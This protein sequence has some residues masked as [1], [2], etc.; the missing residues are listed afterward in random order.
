MTGAG[1]IDKESNENNAMNHIILLGDSVFDN[2]EYVGENSSV[3]DALKS[4]MDRNAKVTLLAVDGNVTADV[5]VQLQSLPKNATHLFISCGGNDALRQAHILNE[6]V[7]SV[8]D[9]MMVLFEVIKE[10][11]CNY[12][13][14]LKTA[15][16]NNKNIALCTIYNSS[17][18]I[19]QQA[20]T[21][22]A[23]FNEIILH[24]AVKHQLPVIDL[25]MLCSEA[26]DFSKISPIEPSAIGASKIAGRIKSLVNYHQYGS[27]ET[28]IYT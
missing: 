22:L 20:F 17:P 4:I 27:S 7:T 21:V 9:A 12:H 18:G 24:E 19:S 13:R 6:R 28:R 5:L 1:E 11:Q 26:A 23:L 10:F 3:Q 15:L 25:R 14:M 2:A 8:G 16:R